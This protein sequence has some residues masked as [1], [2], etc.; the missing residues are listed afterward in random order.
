[1]PVVREEEGERM[2]WTGAAALPSAFHLLDRTVA[3][4]HALLQRLLNVCINQG[5]QSAGETEGAC[6]R[7]DDAQGLPR[8]MRLRKFM[9][10]G[11][12]S[13]LLS[14][15]SCCRMSSAIM[16]GSRAACMLYAAA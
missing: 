2:E 5:T 13:T 4:V 11:M 16:D 15:R 10:P 1:M 12:A 14:A 3:A 9:P 7:P 6:A 8:Y